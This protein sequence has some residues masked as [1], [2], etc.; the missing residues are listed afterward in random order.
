MQSKY[1]L[2]WVGDFTK[3]LINAVFR[4]LFGNYQENMVGIIKKE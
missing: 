2:I 1:V 4:D 3:I